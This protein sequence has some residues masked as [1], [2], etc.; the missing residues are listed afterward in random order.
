LI[1][2]DKYNEVELPLLQYLKDHPGSWRAHY[3]QGYVLFRSRKVGDS[4]RELARSLELNVNNP[5]AHKMLGKDLV[6]IGKFDYAQTEL[7]QAVRLKPDSAEIHYSLGEVYSARDMFPAA[8]AEFTAAI[9]L[10]GNYAEAFNALGFTEESLGDDAH[11]LQAYQR[12]IDIAE[13]QKTKFA[14][15][16]VNLGAYYNREKKPELALE[17]A[18]KAIERDPKSDLG[19]YQAARAHQIRNEWE[20]AAEALRKASSINPSS[21]Q[22][23]YVLADV[24]RKLGKPKESLAALDTFQRLKRESD[25]VDNQVRDAREASVNDSKAVTKQR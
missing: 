2:Q 18:R 12:A 23:Y 15:P 7:Q 4:I 17:Y 25:L 9:Q 16:Y 10:D 24:Y 20:Q 8:K 22:Y 21:A 13:R 3:L 5:E 1:R 14:A 11:A 6:L 19:Y